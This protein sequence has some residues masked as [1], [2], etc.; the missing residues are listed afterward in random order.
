MVLLDITNATNGR[1]GSTVWTSAMLGW[2]WQ[3]SC[4]CPMFLLLYVILEIGWL[5]CLMIPMMTLLLLLLCLGTHAGRT[6]G[7]HS[8]HIA[9]IW[10]EPILDLLQLILRDLLRCIWERHLVAVTLLHWARDGLYAAIIITLLLK[11][12]KVSLFQR[13]LSPAVI[14]GSLTSW[15][16]Q[17]P[18]RHSEPPSAQRSGK[19]WEVIPKRLSAHQNFLYQFV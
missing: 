11:T 6:I 2:R 12:S 16:L 5:D 9:V 18:Q 4:F 15:I 14:T 19:W 13:G 8:R 1:W 3:S 10:S 17:R 7:Y